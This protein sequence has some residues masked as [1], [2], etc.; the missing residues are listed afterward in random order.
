MTKQFKMSVDKNAL[1]RVTKAKHKLWTLINN[2]EDTEK[3]N[4]PIVPRVFQITYERAEHAPTLLV[5]MVSGLVS[6]RHMAVCT[7]SLKMSVYPLPWSSRCRSFT[8]GNRQRCTVQFMYEMSF[9][10]ISTIGGK[11]KWP[12]CQTT[13]NGLNYQ[14]HW[15][16]VS[17]KC[18]PSAGQYQL[19]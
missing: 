18:L 1:S 16:C 15:S 13:G 14:N 10:I 5:Q 8:G 17:E 11:C 12:K 6:G 4:I 9:T 3:T 19:R 2:T 7:Q